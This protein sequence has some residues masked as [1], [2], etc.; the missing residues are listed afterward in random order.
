MERKE[1]AQEQTEPATVHSK[2]SKP[3]DEDLELELIKEG[4][5]IH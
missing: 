4:S 3:S 1:A 5:T 2:H